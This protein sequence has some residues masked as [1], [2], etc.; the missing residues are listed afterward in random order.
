[1]E[2]RHFLRGAL[3]AATIAVTSLH[4]ARA[5]AGDDAAAALAQLAGYFAA[6][7]ARDFGR[8]YRV[9]ERGG[10]ASGQTLAAFIEGF[11]HTATV[12][13]RLGPP[14]RIEGAAGSR[15]IEIPV[16]LQ[17]RTDAGEQQRFEGRYVLR[18]VVVDGATPT[19][20]QW[21]IASAHMVRVP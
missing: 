16:R 12:D 18:R 4:P 20:R 8:A 11:A 17:A 2:R 21:H 5:Q 15:Y 19:Q 14:G 7:G 9:W 6:I 10:S 3:V 1:M 13:A